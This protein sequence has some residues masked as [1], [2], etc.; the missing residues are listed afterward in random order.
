VIRT[1]LASLLLVLLVPVLVL[2]NLSVWSLRTVVDDRA[3]TA[4]VSRSLD[5][6]AVDALIADT[7][8]TAVLDGIQRASASE[9]LAG[10]QALGLPIDADDEALRERI[11]TRVLGALDDPTVQDAR[12]D[13]VEAAHAFLMDAARG[14]NDLVRIEGRDVILDV[15]PI[16]ERATDRIDPR[17]VAVIRDRLDPSTMRLV[18]ASS[19]GIR[20]VSATVVVLDTLRWVIPLLVVAA[21]LLIVVVAH[22]RVRALGAVGVAVMIAGLISL[23]VVWVGGIAAPTTLDDP[24]LQAVAGEVYGALT[25]ALVAQSIGLVTAGLALVIVA[26]VILRRRRAGAA[27]RRPV[28]P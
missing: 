7:V 4:T 26:W 1:A 6:P 2:A 10:V 11:E 3:F 19:D 21:A 25:V 20:V 15:R 9:R 18:I 12:D 8:T 16:V 14:S 17:F 5:T 27:A 24:T 28:A 22:R 13:A 23:V